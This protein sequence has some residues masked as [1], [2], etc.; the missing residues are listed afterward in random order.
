MGKPV[1]QGKS[2]KK[3]ALP[4]PA[5][6][7]QKSSSPIRHH[8]SKLII[9]GSMLRAATGPGQ[10]MPADTANAQASTHEAAQEDKQAEDA[11]GRGAPKIAVTQTAKQSQSTAGPTNP[12]KHFASMSAL[13]GPEGSSAPGI[14]QAAAPESSQGKAGSEGPTP[15][16]PVPSPAKHVTTLDPPG[17]SQG[18]RGKDDSMDVKQEPTGDSSQGKTG[19]PGRGSASAQPAETAAAGTAAAEQCTGD[20]AADE[21]HTPSPALKTSLGTG[22]RKRKS[23]FPALIKR[24]KCFSVMACCPTSSK[25]AIHLYGRTLSRAWE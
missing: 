10:A 19:V 8:T 23:A 1:V 9:K 3:D 17:P 21:K 12:G 16:Q 14:K 13:L 24:F 5:P 18:A 11:P 20:T 2:S 25:H 22:R 15:G 6:E 4:E 7:K